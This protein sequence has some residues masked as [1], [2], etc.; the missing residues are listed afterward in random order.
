M[1]LAKYRAIFVEDSTENL[2]EISRA[3]LELEKDPA[4]AE[5]IAALRGMGSG[6][7]PPATALK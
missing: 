7:V 3:L 1:D 6:H 4:R 5:A 2:G